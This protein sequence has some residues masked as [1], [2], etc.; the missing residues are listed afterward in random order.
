MIIDFRLSLPRFLS[1]IRERQ[2]WQII[3]AP[4][5]FEYNEEDYCVD[6]LESLPNVSI[7]NVDS[8]FTFPSENFPIQWVRFTQPVRIH[9][10]RISDLE[11]NQL[12]P[13]T[14][15]LTPTVDVSYDI[16][17]EGISGDPEG[18]ELCVQFVNI[19]FKG[20]QNVIPQEVRDQIQATLQFLSC[21]PF[22]LT[23][24]RALMR[25]PSDETLQI[26]HAGVRVDND[27]TRY[28]AIRIQ[29]GSLEGKWWK[30]F[31]TAEDVDLLGSDDWCTYLDKS[32]LVSIVKRMWN[33]SLSKAPRFDLS[34]GVS[35][36]W[37]KS[38]TAV[39]LNVSF[40]GEVIDACTCAWKEIDVDVDVTGTMQLSVP[41]ADTLRWRVSLDHD[42]DGLEE[43][44]CELTAAAFWPAVG[45]ILLKKDQVTWLEYLG[46]IFLWLAGGAPILFILAIMEASG[47]KPLDEVQ[48]PPDCHKESDKSFVCEQPFQG[49][50]QV[51]GTLTL[52]RV[53]RF[54]VANA[55]SAFHAGGLRMSGT[56]VTP[57]ETSVPALKVSASTEPFKWFIPAHECVPTDNIPP[58]FQA[59]SVI[60]VV[61]AS[62]FP[63]GPFYNCNVQVL[64]GDPFQVYEPWITLNTSGAPLSS[65]F[66]I[67]VHIPLFA[68]SAEY[69]AKP[70]P[71]KLL[72]QTNA[73]ARIITFPA[74]KPPTNEQMKTAESQ[75]VMAIQ[76]ICDSK[77]VPYDEYKHHYI[78]PQPDPAHITLKDPIF[79]LWQLIYRAVQIGDVLRISDGLGRPLA[80]IDVNR[81]GLVQLSITTEGKE[82]ARD[83]ILTHKLMR[84]EKETSDV[85]RSILDIRQTPALPAALLSLGSSPRQ[86]AAGL[87]EGVP[88]LLVNTHDTISAIDV[89]FPARPRSLLQL[90]VPGV[91][92]SLI[93]ESA[94]FIWGDFGLERLEMD[95]AGVHRRAVIPQPG[96][97]SARS[98]VDVTQR[99]TSLFILTTEDLT[100]FDL[101]NGRR[102]TTP[103][104]NASN[105][106]L[107]RHWV[108][109]GGKDGMSVLARRDLARVSTAPIRI[110]NVTQVKAKLPLMNT[111][112]DV[113]YVRTQ[114]GQRMLLDLSRPDE[115]S[116]LAHF[117][118]TP[119]YEDTVRLGRVLVRPQSGSSSILIYV[120]DSSDQ[121]S[122]THREEA[123]VK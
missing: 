5:P 112:D 105:I 73:G 69:L 72:I 57:Q 3:C 31:Y 36:T 21:T 113:V 45:A 47:K 46:G 98:V 8:G 9:I 87:I 54:A 19:D 121:P 15:A 78:P 82:S 33:E 100:V 119:W 92:G 41:T 62:A 13:T 89:S 56:L 34:S 120:L 84:G 75:W 64:E 61:N 35:V 91:R 80:A 50:A 22:D 114:S 81:I 17:I 23:P 2:K 71:L 94:I 37:S 10:V 51:Y 55:A 118:F 25:L 6:H 12:N 111:L 97:A 101:A 63:H 83:L 14:A 123:F 93:Q 43:L 29:L 102:E 38:G 30:D 60:T 67:I 7:E 27:G 122:L 20:F 40:S 70:Y 52:T 85:S 53:E 68:L 103:V 77:T 86:L 44:C 24:I 108:I 116:E 99:G 18:L 88:V 59:R 26:A 74:I 1:Y 90:R 117:E 76:L 65:A 66:S 109:L 32:I 58:T 49:K 96:K 4:G 104:A 42:A 16:R 106:A 28:F 79:H 48:F 11:A 107:S 39:K 110:R 115:A 95:S